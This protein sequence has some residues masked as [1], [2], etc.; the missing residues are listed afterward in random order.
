MIDQA[1]SRRDEHTKNEVD[2]QEKTVGQEEKTEGKEETASNASP[3]HTTEIVGGRGGLMTDPYRTV[4]DAITIARAVKQGWVGPWNTSEETRRKV[5]EAF[6]HHLDRA[7][8]EGDSRGVSRFGRA[9]AD[10]QRDNNT[11]ASDLDK[12][13]RLDQGK[14]TEHVVF[15]KIEIGKAR[16]NG[17]HD[18]MEPD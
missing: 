2:G 12:A 17:S 10:L 6:E 7:I 4:T 9:L 5:T 3:S 13:T 16:P 18:G 1:D 14:A 11:L 8:A 15:G